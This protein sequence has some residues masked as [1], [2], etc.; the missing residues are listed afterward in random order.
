[1]DDLLITFGDELK[2]AGDGRFTGRLVRFSSADDKDLA[3]D[4]FTKNTDFGI[5]DGQTTPIYFN[6]RLPIST[7]DKKEI[8]IKAKIGE[9]A[10]TV[11]DEGV[12]IDAI[13]FNREKYEKAIIKAG[14]AK[15]LG[16]SSG[17]AKHLVDRDEDGFIKT[18]PLGLD[19]SVTPTP[20]E[21]HNDALP[22][23]TYTTVEFAPV[24]ELDELLQPKP[25]GSIKGL[26]QDKLADQTPSSWQLESVFRDVLRDIA[27][28]AS[29]TDIT[30]VSVDVQAKVQEAANEY[31]AALVPLA[32]S[33]I[34]EHV[35]SDS[36]DPFY[37]KS[38]LDEFI[39]SGSELVSDSNLE[40]HSRTVVSALTEFAR[41]G[42]ALAEPL[43]AF[44]ERVKQK[45][46]F[47]IKAGRVISSAN[48]DKLSELLTLLDSLAAM[49][50]EMRAA[51][52]ELVSMAEP[53]KP[54][55]TMK[56]LRMQTLRLQSRAVGVPV[57]G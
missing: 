51:V 11:D 48:R 47:R 33:Q 49:S 23:K 4:Y 17:T 13:I 7:R 29:T 19:A 35:E 32:V 53:K 46:E 1:M 16:W 21:P 5:K 42:G 52:S 39:A 12:L 14:K 6:H 41:K 50:K 44:A 20:C 37:L 25:I 18:W 55:S 8:V 38:L 2:S 57:G 26:F 30:G 54:E 28:A 45:Q 36:R 27:S 9:G 3:G 31:V 24:E 56:A 40:E 43:K 34:N 15:K 22:V 10:L